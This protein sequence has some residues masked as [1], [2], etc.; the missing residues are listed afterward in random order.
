[1]EDLFAFT[2]ESD[3]LRTGK[4]VRKVEEWIQK[5]KKADNQFIGRNQILNVK[6]VSRRDDEGF[7][8]GHVYYHNPYYYETDESPTT[9][10]TTTSTST[11]T[12]TTT[13]FPVTIPHKQLPEQPSGGAGL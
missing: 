7:Y 5:P 3:F 9:T 12:T 2:D 1:M 6:I 10:T 13:C 11:T 4:A 8:K